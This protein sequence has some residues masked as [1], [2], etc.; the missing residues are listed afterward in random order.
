[1][2]EQWKTCVYNGVIYED[3]EVSTKGNI[4]SLNYRHTGEIR[5][6]KQRIDEDGYLQVGLT[7]NKSRKQ[8][9]VH[10]L[11]AIAYIF[12]DNPTVKTQ[13]NHIDED[14]TNNNVDNLEWVSPK[15]NIHHGTR[16][17]RVRKRVRCIELDKIYDSMT[18]AEVETG[19][20]DGSIGKVCRG[21][22]KT[23]GGF[24]WEYV[25]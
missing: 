21:E 9:R 7:K 25:D 18:Q 20:D 6:L 19:L 24:H 15:E 14:K 3:Y 13:V 5:I 11:V 1:M 22:R 10:R 17:E 8:C 23:C 16:T 2:E 4:R 12:N